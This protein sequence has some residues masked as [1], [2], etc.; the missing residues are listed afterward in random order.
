[1]VYLAQM[2]LEHLPS[3]GP[4]FRAIYLPYGSSANPE[5][6]A[7]GLASFLPQPARVFRIE[8]DLLLPEEGRALADALGH[9]CTVLVIGHAESRLLRC[10]AHQWPD[11]CEH[12]TRPASIFRHV[13]LE[14][15]EG[16]DKLACIYLLIPSLDIHRSDRPA[17]APL[18]EVDIQKLISLAAD[19]PS[20]PQPLGRRG[21][22]IVSAGVSMRDLC[23]LHERDSA[24][25]R[26]RSFGEFINATDP[27]S[28]RELQTV[29]SAQPDI[30]LLDYL[31]S[32]LSREQYDFGM[33][34][35]KYMDE[36]REAAAEGIYPDIYAAVWAMEKVLSDDTIF[37][38]QFRAEWGLESSLMRPN[39]SGVLD[40]A[41]LLRRIELTSDFI[42]SVRQRST[43][44]F[45]AQLDEDSLLA[46]AQHFGFP[47]PLLDFTESFRVAAFFAT[48]DA[49]SIKKA[50][51]PIGVIYYIF[52]A[53]Q[54]QTQSDNPEDDRLM[55]WA[56]VRPGSLHVIRPDIPDGD[57]RIRRQRGRF[58]GG[59]RARHLQA[60]TID[61]IYFKQHAGLTFEDP[62][63]GISAEQ[64]LPVRTTLSAMADE[65][66][67]RVR[68]APAM[69]GFLSLTP[70]SDSSVIGS[71]DAHLYWHLRFGREYL[72]ALKEQASRIDA[73]PVY[74][75]IESALDRYFSMAKVEADISLCPDREQS[76]AWMTPIRKT[77]ASLEQ[78]ACLQEG[79]IWSLVQKQLPKGFEYGGHVR[80]DVPEKWSKS[81]HLAFSCA[82]FCIAWE[83][84]RCVPGLR[85]EELVQSAT[86]TLHG[87]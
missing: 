50:D 1:V 54:K 81:A 38:G 87:W 19:S 57:D 76:Q 72:S 22:G 83:H 13:T 75:A 40:V 60:V 34:A 61:R 86:F 11:Y 18:S 3:L 47:T 74:Q 84:L 23:Q 28:W 39:T 41:E 73:M 49:A 78:A 25:A 66:R 29:L 43:E 63:A 79:E 31:R 15:A 69:S 4:I 42:S 35:V 48:Q 8:S 10:L 70:L 67:R 71:A 55:R 68:M 27:L 30:S 46:V 17:V 44:L 20:N 33:A 32:R 58:V 56:G 21:A 12:F 2:E 24:A 85:A 16:P 6:L 82:I 7:S 45:G 65:I 9:S 59:Y 37:R 14:P 80:F 5:L 53:D 77:V 36:H 64:L 52:S 26:L 62:R 51:P